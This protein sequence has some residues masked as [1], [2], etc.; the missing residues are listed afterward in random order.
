[1]CARFRLIATAEELVE[2]FKL[3]KELNL[4]PRY[5][6]APTQPVLAVRQ[7]GPAGPRVDHLMHWGLILTA[8]HFSPGEGADADLRPVLV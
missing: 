5:N 6:I 1:M 7:G 2:W 4:A 8:L 3:R